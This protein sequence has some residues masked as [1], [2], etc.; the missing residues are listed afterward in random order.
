MQGSAVKGFSAIA[1][2]IQIILGPNCS[3]WSAS[4]ASALCSAVQV[5]CS[6]QLSRRG[7][8][9]RRLMSRELRVKEISTFTSNA[10]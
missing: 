3:E 4:P 1:V 7:R 6:R 9:C 10:A 2:A 8:T 5:Q